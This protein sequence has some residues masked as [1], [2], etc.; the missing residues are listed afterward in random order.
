MNAGGMT[1]KL[2][3]IV[4]RDWLDSV[5]HRTGFIVPTGT[6]AAQLAGFYFFARAIGPHYRPD[7]MD[8]YPFLLVGTAM[9]SFYISGVNGFVSTLKEAQ[10]NGALEVMMNT[11]TPAP[12]MVALSAFSVF[13][14]RTLRLVVFIAAGVVPYIHTLRP[15]WAAGALVIL[16]S[17]LVAVS[18][19]MLAASAQ[20]LLH[21][22]DAVVW[23]FGSAG[24]LLTG[25]AFP[26]SGL[27]AGLRQV[28]SLIPATYSIQAM[29]AALLQG[30]SWGPVA[31]PLTLLAIAAALLVPASAAVLGAVVHR[32][33]LDGTLSYY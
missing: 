14:G 10:I 32:A 6:M 1:R 17:V 23:L 29:R 2:A 25:M 31:R 4:R 9:F 11:S 16:L 28:A 30:A 15:N 24:W 13:A 20:V 19:G 33:R 5:R 18:A 12:L 8:Y 22:G 21:R 27:P 26:V 7:G 3:A